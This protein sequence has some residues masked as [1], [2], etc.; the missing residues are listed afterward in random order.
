MGPVR[1]P[2]ESRALAPRGFTLIEILVVIAILAIAA[3]V[4]VV[5]YDGSD[6][7]RATREARRFAGALEHA[8]ARAQVRAETLGASA[9][10]RHVAVLAARPRQR[11]LA[12]D[13][14]RRR[15]SRR[16]RC[17]RRCARAAVAT[18]AGRVDADAIVPFR[19]DGT[20]RALR[21]RACSRA[22]R[23]SCS[24]PIRSTASRSCRGRP[25][26]RAA[27]GFTLVEILV[28][29]AIV[30]IALTAGMRA[31]AQATDTRLGAQGAHARAV[32]RAESPR[33]RADRIAVARARQLRGRRASRPAPLRVAGDASATTPNP[34]F[35][36]IEIVVAEPQLARLRA[37]APHR[38]PRQSGAAA[39]DARTRARASR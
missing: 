3:G 4:A 29:L 28:A 35:R 1:P 22:T 6:R 24:P 37:R 13:R 14:R 27:R 11:T 9:D 38:L 34:A 31:L 15:C 19:P 25:R 10:G 2:N 12:A 5:A 39:D 26:E 20:Q 36:R 21:V 17:P 32:G 23:A 8:A 7:D 18:A 30:A 16:T 33:R